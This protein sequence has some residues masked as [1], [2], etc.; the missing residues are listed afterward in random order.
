MPYLQRDG[1]DGLVDKFH[2][3]RRFEMR[4]ELFIKNRAFA[5]LESR[6]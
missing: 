5:A 2:V 3:V 6:P 4:E 1:D